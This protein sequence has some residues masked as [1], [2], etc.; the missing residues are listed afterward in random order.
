MK[1]R[2]WYAPEFRNWLRAVFFSL[3]LMSYQPL[4]FVLAADAIGKAASHAQQEPQPQKA[5]E[6]GKED[7]AQMEEDRTMKVIVDSRRKDDEQIRHPAIEI[8]AIRNVRRKDWINKLEIEVK[9]ITSKPIYSIR[10]MLL[11]PDILIANGTLG[12]SIYFGRPELNDYHREAGPEDQPLKPGETCILG[13]DKS[14]RDFLS[15]DLLRRNPDGS[16][17]KNILLSIEEITFGDGTG[18]MHGG[19]FLRAVKKP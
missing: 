2:D 4:S 14:R 8:R 15:R 11:F 17:R 6:Q 16:K 7:A 19:I 18:F 13:I 3:A 5:Q 12:E 10:L 1:N 9:N